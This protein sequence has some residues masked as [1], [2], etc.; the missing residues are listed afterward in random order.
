MTIPE[1]SLLIDM[2][3]R[4]AIL[5]KSLTDILK[6]HDLLSEEDTKLFE[7]YRIQAEL[8]NPTVAAETAK[9]YSDLAKSLGLD[10]PIGYSEA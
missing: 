3:I 1:H 9:I 2:V 7:S 4:Q 6:S 8:M 10:V 5:L